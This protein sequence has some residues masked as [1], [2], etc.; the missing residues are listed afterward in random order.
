LLA[1]D[2]AGFGD[3]LRTA[4]VLGLALLREAREGT[5]ALPDD[6]AATVIR[7]DDEQFVGTEIDLEIAAYAVASL[8]D[9][10]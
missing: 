1:F 5:G 8:L 2:R 3:R 6:L 7:W 10:D 4:H 9:V